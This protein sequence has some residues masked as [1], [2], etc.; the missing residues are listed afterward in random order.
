MEIVLSFFPVLL[1][2]GF[3][4]MM[5]SF[6]LV[7]ISS[8]LLCLGWGIISAISAFYVNTFIAGTLDLDFR[9]LSRY[10][11]P[12]TEE[13]IKSMAIVVMIYKKRQGFL[14]DAA[15]YGFAVGTGFSL[16]E[17]IIYFLGTPP[18][19]ALINSVIRGFGT[20]FMHGGC[21]GLLAV[22]FMAG[23]ERSGSF[24]LSGFIGL[25]VA[26]LIHSG[27]NHFPLPP[28][29]QT[30]V[31]MVVMPLLF[32]AIF[33]INT[34]RLQKWLEIEFSS[35]VELLGMIR[36]GEFG[37]TKSGR[38]LAS[39]REQFTPEVVFDMYC[40]LSLYI[41]LSIKAKRNI[42]LQEGGFPLIREEDLL[43]KLE[44]LKMLRRR[45]GKI[46]ELALAPLIRMNY[47]NLWK[48]TKLRTV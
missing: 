13:F 44:E 39:L 4:F 33:R 17:N 43:Q 10:V 36:K 11:A 5:D 25:I 8:L 34:Q 3:L 26:I 24:L 7:R 1:F 40:F 29:Y 35:E 45:I 41:E 27:F 21:T 9:Q 19:S 6:R 28:L 12:L 32:V 14:V 47:R 30:L 16:A 2:L 22:F 46:G 15:V 48:L 37:G 20:A 38:Y 23:I 31:N 42:M 18:E